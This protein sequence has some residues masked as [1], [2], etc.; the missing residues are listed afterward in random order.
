VP[1]S[2]IAL[3]AAAATG[4]GAIAAFRR[5]RTLLGPSL[6]TLIVATAFLFPRIDLPWE[7]TLLAVSVASLSLSLLANRLLQARERG[8]TSRKLAHVEH[9]EMIEMAGAAAVTP[10]RPATPEQRPGG[11]GSFGGAGATGEF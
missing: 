11:G 3:T 4:L 5:D 1:L 6:L 8:I 10:E 2:A 7:W 9:E